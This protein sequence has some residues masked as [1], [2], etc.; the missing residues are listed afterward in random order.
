MKMPQKQGYIVKRVFAV[1]CRNCMIDQPTV[2]HPRHKG[3]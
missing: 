3:G 2:L 1:A